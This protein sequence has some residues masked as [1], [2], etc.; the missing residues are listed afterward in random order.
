[1][2]K[3]ADLVLLDEPTPPEANDPG[4]SWF[5]R[6]VK[7]GEIYGKYMVKD[8]KTSRSMVSYGKSQ[9]LF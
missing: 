2:L 6:L 1:M 3:H 8:G 5:P 9:R 4:C 7:Y